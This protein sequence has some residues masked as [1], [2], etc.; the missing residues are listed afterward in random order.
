LHCNII[1]IIL[2]QPQE[3][4]K[5]AKE[6]EAQIKDSHENLEESDSS[7]WDNLQK[8]WDEAARYYSKIKKYTLVYLLS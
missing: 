7:F 2:F 5:W 6:F 1:A 3:S 8:Q 4:D